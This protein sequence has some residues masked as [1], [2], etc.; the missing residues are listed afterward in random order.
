MTTFASDQATIYRPPALL[1]QNLIR[2]DT[3][4]PPG[5]ESEC[6]KYLDSLITAAGIQTS[7]FALD[8]G[9]PNLVARLKGQGK[10]PP[11]LLC[12]HVDVVSTE[13][14]SWQHPPFGGEIADG[15]IW[16]RGALDMK[17]GV[18]MMVS[19]FLRAKS[20]GFVP[21]GD[22]IL[23]I[24][25]DEER[26]SNFGAKYLVENHAPL[27][28]GV[29]YALGEFG[30]FT[31]YI[32]QKRFYP[33]MVAEKGYCLL[34]ASIRGKGGYFSLGIR[35]S[36]MSKL[37]W[38]LQQLDQHRTPIHITSV[39]RRFIKTLAD[40]LPFPSNLILKQVLNPKLSGGI[41]RTLGAKGEV[42]EP[43]LHNTI[44]ATVI[45]GADNISVIP[46]NIILNLPCFVVP[47]FSTD[48]LIS[49][50]H[51]I[52]GQDVELKVVRSE[53]GPAEPD[54]GLFDMLGKILR[55]ADPKG[56]PLPLLLPTG[57][58]GRFLSRLGIQT[59]GFTPMLFA[60]DFNFWQN[61]H[62]A[63]ERIPV[64]ALD[65]GTEAIYKVIQRFGK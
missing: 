31:F 50:L 28:Q 30:G 12:G 44:N 52:I 26:G 54:M 49:E 33:I 4:N 36:T 43:M 47:G 22:V 63:N 32:G 25:S 1:L 8:P 53:L 15:Y 34:E 56:I 58:D 59:Y 18:A 21:P 38:T 41:L 7:I 5:N 6:V 13:N 29:R 61:T 51:Q 40:N 37:G 27:F 46:E 23:A 55:E 35:D 20:E 39:T 48:D 16:G 57:T 17:G 9:R 45:R 24:V 2:F 14:Q 42:F 65:F 3:T 10:V 19:A 11:F 60:K 64:E 62:S